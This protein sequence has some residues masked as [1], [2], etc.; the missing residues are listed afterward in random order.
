MWFT[1]LESKSLIKKAKALSC[2]IRETK[3]AGQSIR[4]E[5][6]NAG[7][8]GL[9]IRVACICLKPTSGNFCILYDQI[10]ARHAGVAGSV[11][12]VNIVGYSPRNK[13]V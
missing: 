13:Y 10:D 3:G 11:R 8:Q 4:T 2:F 5:S 6:I 1:A 7:L 9:K 12:L